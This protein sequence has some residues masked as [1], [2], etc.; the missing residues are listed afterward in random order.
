MELQ[1]KALILACVVLGAT[2]SGPALGAERSTLGGSARTD[3]P[4]ATEPSVAPG[5]DSRARG[6]PNTA[7]LAMREALARAACRDRSGAEVSCA[8]AAN[9]HRYRGALKHGGT[10]RR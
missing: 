8:A 10:K 5:V 4:P 2:I 6:G 1:M 3:Q 7:S 9:E